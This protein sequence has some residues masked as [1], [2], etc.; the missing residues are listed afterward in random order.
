MSIETAGID[1]LGDLIDM[2][3]STA[4]WLWDKGIPQWEPG[5]FERDRESL[6]VLV[7]RGWILGIRSSDGGFAAG[8]IL[9]RLRPPIWPAG[10]TALYLGSLAVARTSAGQAL[11]NAIFDA[12][13]DTAREDGAAELRL[14]CWAGNEVL[15]HYYLNAGFTDRGTTG[16]LDYQVRRFSKSPE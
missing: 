10:T 8:C 13:L 2:L 6:A 4:R 3:E 12:A 5:S 7:E 16:E 14:D 15:R 1:A 9:T 11:G